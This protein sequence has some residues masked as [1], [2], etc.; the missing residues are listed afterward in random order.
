MHACIYA[1]PLK[2]ASH[3]PQ[4]LES[5]SSACMH[6][7]RARTPPRSLGWNPRPPPNLS[8][9]ETSPPSYS[10]RRRQEHRVLGERSARS[11]ARAV[12]RWNCNGNATASSSPSR[13]APEISFPPHVVRISSNAT[14]RNDLDRWW[15]PRGRKGGELEV[16]PSGVETGRAGLASGI[17]DSGH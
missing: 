9:I 6:R 10:R 13:T 5:G 12:S 7:R 3:C 14:Q 4:R 1:Y 16:G 15:M 17:S 11:P 2:A 8:A